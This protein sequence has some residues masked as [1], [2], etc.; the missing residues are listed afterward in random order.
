[1][2]RQLQHIAHLPAPVIVVMNT[3]LVSGGV[4]LITMRGIE[5]IEDGAPLDQ[6]LRAMI[7]TKRSTQLY[8][9]LNTLDYVVDRVGHLQAF[10]GGMLKIRPVMAIRNGLVEDVAKVRGQAKSRMRMLELVKEQA[11]DRPIDVIVLHSLA[12]DE[13]RELQ[14]QVLASLNVHKSWITGIGCTVSRFTG[15]GGLGIV[16]AEA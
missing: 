14:S 5:G 16:F 1:M 8:F 3:D 12:P 4:G 9:I 7:E 11:G 10:L 6:V 2:E 15:R 13:A